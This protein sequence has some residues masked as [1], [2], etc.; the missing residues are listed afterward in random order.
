[1][2]ALNS[3]I[4]A[5]SVE[6]PTS[7][8]EFRVAI[9]ASTDKK[10]V[11]RLSGGANMPSMSEEK[12]IFAKNQAP[13]GPIPQGESDITPG[14]LILP[15][16][17]S[18]QPW[19]MALRT[20]GESDNPSDG[21]VKVPMDKLSPP[22]SPVSLPSGVGD[23]SHRCLAGG[24]VSGANRFKHG[25][26]TDVLDFVGRRDSSPEAAL[27]FDDHAT[28][29]LGEYTV[30]LIGIEFAATQEKCSQCQRSY[31]LSEIALDENCQP[32]CKAC[33]SHIICKWVLNPDWAT[34]QFGLRM[35]WEV[36][37]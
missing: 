28:V 34:A 27:S 3:E 22:S 30:P 5:V 12:S 16:P 17:D 1:M 32:R 36:A 7:D 18:A 37:P 24:N 11:A 13:G 8:S 20:D 2:A 4:R 29:K 15:R 21:G 25:S 33:S 31:H 26:D 10:S 6:Y 14:A 19:T 23:A 35:A 9:R